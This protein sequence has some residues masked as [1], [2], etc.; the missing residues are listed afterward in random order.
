L[1]GFCAL[2]RLTNDYERIRKTPETCKLSQVCQFK[3]N[4]NGTKNM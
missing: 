3:E 1:F 2:V 4:L